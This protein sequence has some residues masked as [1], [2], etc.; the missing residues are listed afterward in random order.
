MKRLFHIFRGRLLSRTMS[1]IC[2]VCGYGKFYEPPVDDRG[3]SARA[4][5]FITDMMTTI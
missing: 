1:N 3:F 2:L 5:D 4:A